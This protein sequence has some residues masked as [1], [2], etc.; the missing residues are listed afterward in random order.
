MKKQ[1]KGFFGTIA[2]WGRRLFRGGSAELVDQMEQ[3]KK[4]PT[5]DVEEIVSPTRQIIRGFMERK[6]AVFALIVV[7]VMMLTVFIGPLFMKNYSDSYT[8][9]TQKNVPPTMSMMS[10]PKEL[11]NDIKMIDSFGSFSVGLSNA[12]KVYVWGSTKMGTSGVDM[13][14]IP[15]EIKDAKI[16]QIAAGMD[17]AIAI[18]ENGKV[19]AWGVNKLGQYG[20]FDPAEYPTVVF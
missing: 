19:Y 3:N 18:D 15:Q 6:L 5:K 4:D 12:G 9:V 17:H 11:K 8:E 10:V 20:Y 1:K 16:V 7:V 2:G 14:D 13:K